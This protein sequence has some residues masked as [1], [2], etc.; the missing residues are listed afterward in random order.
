MRIEALFV[1]GRILTMDRARP[2]VVAVAVAGGKVLAAGSSAELLAQRDRDTE[3]IDLGGRF[4][5]P[6]FIDPHNHFSLNALAPLEVDCRTPPLA[7]ISQL[8]E[9]IRETAQELPQGAWVRGHGY[10]EEHLKERRHPTRAELD[11]AAPDHPVVLVHWSVHRCALNSV[12][13]DALGIGRETADPPGGWIVRGPDSVPTGTLYETA[14]NPAQ[15]RSI[16]AY[17]ERYDGQA[18]TLLEANARRY[19][20]AGIT[21]VGDAYVS[22]ALARL[23]S[24]APFMSLR[25]IG[26]KGSADGLFAPP[27]P[28]FEIRGSTR[29]GWPDDVHPISRRLL[30]GIKLFTDGGGNTTATT[31]RGEH[32]H[33]GAARLFYGQEALDALVAEAHGR[34][35][36]VAIHAAGDM[37][38][39]MA[40]A[41]MERARQAN[42]R[43]EPRFRIEHG[44]VLSDDLIR[45]LRD[46]GAVLVVQP[47]SVYYHADKLA[48]APLADGLRQLPLRDLLDAGVPVALS[49]DSPC[50]PMDPLFGIWAAITRATQ[51]GGVSAPD[52]R[53]SVEEALR[54]ATCTAARALGLEDER[55]SLTPGKAADLVVLSDDPRALPPDTIR[56]VS[57]EATYRG[58]LCA[59]DRKRDGEPGAVG[60]LP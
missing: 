25:V 4:A 27:D 55:G 57:V 29:R 21:A 41:A 50:Y 14:T 60:R 54:A 9:R 11:E 22:P 17:T 46:A 34:G 44:V 16:A 58:G 51:S 6:A 38:V 43:I 47:V 31:L 26:Y 49:S 42:P 12:A 18:S 13:L 39:H 28:A 7:S 35:L 8:I 5:C 37:A 30:Q 40:L 15:A 20:A 56:S 52:Q 10:D 32:A 48:S 2:E 53:I 1:N 23:Y 19:H 59:Y 36:Q 45:R 33:R 24:H 3:V